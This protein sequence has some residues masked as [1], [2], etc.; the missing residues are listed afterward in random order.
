MPLFLYLIL[1]LFFKKLRL[2]SFCLDVVTLLR[3]SLVFQ[4]KMQLK[5]LFNSPRRS[6]LFEI[7]YFSCRIC[8]A[9]YRGCNNF[10][11]F[12]VRLDKKECFLNDILKAHEDVSLIYE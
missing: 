1:F 9:N 12:S 7:M 6:I 10:E 4:K 11:H 8:Y 5:E 2:S 3:L